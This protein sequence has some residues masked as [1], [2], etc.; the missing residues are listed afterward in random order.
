MKF[1]VK[2]TARSAITAAFAAKKREEAGGLLVAG[3]TL[4]GEETM[5]L[6]MFRQVVARYPNT[7]LL[8]APRHP[9]RFDAVASLLASSGLRYRR[10]SQWEEGPLN[11][12]KRFP[13][14]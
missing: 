4:E 5:L 12:G 1:E 14:R 11:R 10:R 9:E 7:V 6:D 2:P 13:A 3:S 8:L